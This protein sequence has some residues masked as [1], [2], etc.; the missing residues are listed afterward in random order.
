MSPAITRKSKNYRQGI[1]LTELM[2]AMALGSLVILLANSLQKSDSHM[3][4]RVVAAEQIQGYEQSIHKALMS[5]ESKFLSRNPVWARC[6]QNPCDSSCLTQ[7][8]WQPLEWISEKE[9]IHVPVYVYR[10]R[11]SLEEK[12]DGGRFQIRNLKRCDP[13]PQPDTL[14]IDQAPVYPANCSLRMAASWRSGPYGTLEYRIELQD[15]HSKIY[16]RISHYEVLKR[17]WRS[18]G[19]NLG[20]RVYC[21]S[22]GTN[23]L[24]VDFEK[25]DQIC[26]SPLLMENYR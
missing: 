1:T 6:Q 7:R 5:G 18:A 24:M 4:S 8:E 21:R 16:R 20:G 17:D 23:L 14:A 10:I 12:N 19:C 13:L 11:P 15:L 22:Q 2:I 25:Q 26:A 3:H 9:N